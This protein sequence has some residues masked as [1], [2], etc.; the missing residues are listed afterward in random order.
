MI[1]L[2]Q[3]FSSYV[4]LYM[5]LIC[6]SLS[7][8]P[9][10]FSLLSLYPQ[11]S[12]ILPLISLPL[13]PIH[14]YWHVCLHS[15]YGTFPWLGGQHESGSR[16]DDKFFSFALYLSVWR[17]LDYFISQDENKGFIFSD[18]ISLCR[19]PSTVKKAVYWKCY[20]QGVS[21]CYV[22]LA[23]PPPLPPSTYLAWGRRGLGS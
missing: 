1:V 2:F 9:P 4:S 18:T 14:S 11:F 15:R 16:L 6:I 3:I 5:S 10:P 12:S 19:F 20:A 21:V 7:I 17:H 22:S 13:S 8:N 23:L